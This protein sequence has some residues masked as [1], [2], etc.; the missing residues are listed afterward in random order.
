MNF[1]NKTILITGAS[2]GI[3]KALAEKLTGFDCNLVLLSRKIELSAKSAGNGQIKARIEIIKCDVTQKEEVQNAFKRAENTFGKIDVA[4]LNAG[5]GFAVTPEA[6]DS[7]GAE[8]IIKTNFLSSVYWAE[9]LLPGFIDRKEGMIVGVSSL[10][11]NRA[12]GTSFY[13][14]S[15]AALTIFLEGLRI[16]MNKYN[17]K[18][19]TVRP[20]FVKTAMTAGNKYQMPFIISPEKAA[21]IILK[22]I[23][24]EKKMIQFPWPTVF[25]TRLIGMLPLTLFELFLRKPDNQ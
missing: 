4:I 13:N 6:F 16:D 24:K 3:G 11:D 2:S 7:A 17:V 10:A 14:P 19:L 15:K 1:N 18:I 5:T 21:G 12:Y 25:L 20:G 9:A 22:G 23:E 8:K